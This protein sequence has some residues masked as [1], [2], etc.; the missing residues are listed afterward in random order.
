MCQLQLRSWQLT[1]LMPCTACKAACV[2]WSS[3]S[4]GT[5]GCSK[6][7]NGTHRKLS[8]PS[9]TSWRLRRLST[10]VGEK[11]AF[12]SGALTKIIVKSELKSSHIVASTPRMSLVRTLEA[13]LPGTGKVTPRLQDAR[14][15]VP[16][17]SGVDEGAELHAT[18]LLVIHDDKGLRKRIRGLVEPAGR[19]QRLAE[20]VEG[21]R[22]YERPLAVDSDPCLEYLGVKADR[23]VVPARA[24]RAVGGEALIG[25]VPAA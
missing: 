11:K 17:H 12:I 25:D 24:L 10:I 23:L 1:Y 5:L 15:V 21:E 7:Q 14:H 18:E 19:Q 2:S 9:G 22:G 8:T 6:T 4:S 16:A 20:V 13:H 3:P